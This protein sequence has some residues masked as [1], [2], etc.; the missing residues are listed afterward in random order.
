MQSVMQIAW[1]KLKLFDQAVM[2]ALFM[3]RQKRNVEFNCQKL[4]IP[5][6]L[7]SQLLLTASN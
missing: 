4:L 5:F 7:I 2:A 1:L 3:L 6:Y